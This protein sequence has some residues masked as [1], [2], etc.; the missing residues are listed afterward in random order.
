M[1]NASAITCDLRIFSASN[2]KWTSADRL[3]HGSL[4]SAFLEVFKQSTPPTAECGRRRL[5]SEPHGLTW[6]QALKGMR[7]VLKRNLNPQLSR[8]SEFGFNEVAELFPSTRRHYALLISANEQDLQDVE[9]FLKT[10]AAFQT[11]QNDDLELGPNPQI[12]RLSL[13]AETNK[14][15]I[16]QKF[17]VLGERLEIGDSVF[18]YYSGN[19]GHDGDDNDFLIP[20]H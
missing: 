14:E 15:F 1:T 10:F 13:S 3:N 5:E 4:T 9:D 7:L 11:P 18:V 6:N 17:I 16:M 20:I 2:N 19:G 12:M 8:N